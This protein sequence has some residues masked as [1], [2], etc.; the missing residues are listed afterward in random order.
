MPPSVN[1]IEISHTTK[2]LLILCL[3][4]LLLVN[5]GCM[6][7]PDYRRPETSVPSAWTGVGEPAAPAGGVATQ[8]HS[9]AIPQPAELVDWWKTFNDPTLTSL[10]ERAIHSNLDLRQ[11]KA[12]IRQ[13][14]AARG[15]AS[16]AL[17][18]EIDAV[19]DYTYSRGSASTVTASGTSTTVGSI[20]PHSL[21][22]AG[23]DSTWEIDIFGG[24][25]RNIE[26][27][28]ADL[29]AAVEDFRDVLVTLMAEVGTSYV[30]LR[31]YQQQILIAQQNLKSQQHTA[32]ITRKRWEAGFVSALDVA[33]A[34]AQVATTEATIPVMETSARAAIYSLGVL[35]GLQPA[36]L[37]EE[38]SPENLIPPIPPEV[39]VGLPSD[40]VRRRPDIRRTE[41][42]LHAATARIG[43][44]TADL[45]PQFS[46]T[47]SAGVLTADAG[48][49]G[50][51]ASR[52]WSIGPSVTWPIFTGGRILWNIEIQNAVQEQTLAA[53]EKVILT[54]FQD[55]ETSLVA[56]AKEQQHNM[57][58]A[59]AV[60]QNQR[61]V[62]L[63]MKLYLVG[64]IDFLNVLNAQ[65]SLFLTQDGLAV[66][67][68]DM[69]NDLIS[70][71]KAL[72]GG[73]QKAS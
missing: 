40:L 69:A 2:R 61:A 6:V 67:T 39:P 32:D 1:R 65:R 70:L 34:N 3:P 8:Q 72:G 5:T 44:A 19:G 10:E 62:D 7:G 64:K 56:Y 47:G 4:V 71:Y 31:G 30:S 23:F 15:V 45:F 18:P 50:N 51:F 53:Y 33:N 28:E 54:A 57:S 43:V 63:S 21:F 48:M 27:T 42:Q 66:S 12:R 35:L 36:A 14:R 68:R 20:S 24:T 49:L 11:A 22:Q 73:W 58:L 13:A 9:V 52:T 41:A 38:L 60:K 59:E 29:H 25:R 37:V 46:L 26:A 16:S 17:W 55:V